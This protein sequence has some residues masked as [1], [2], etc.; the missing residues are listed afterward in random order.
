MNIDSIAPGDTVHFK[1]CD[2]NEIHAAKVLEIVAVPKASVYSPARK[3]FVV[4]DS[5]H[6]WIHR[7]APSDLRY[8]RS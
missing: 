4:K 7:L 5:A 2:S 1:L 6:G 3:I 8:W